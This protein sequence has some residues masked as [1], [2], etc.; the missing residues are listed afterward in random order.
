MVL[1]KFISFDPII[2]SFRLNIFLELK[3]ELSVLYT[4]MVIFALKMGS[5]FFC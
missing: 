5:I 3:G 1:K 2:F 4:K